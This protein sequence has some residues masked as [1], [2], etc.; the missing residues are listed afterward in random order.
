MKEELEAKVKALCELKDLANAEHGLQL[1]F[2][3]DDDWCVV[4]KGVRFS[5]LPC[6]SV[7]KFL[8]NVLCGKV[9]S[10]EDRGKKQAVEYWKNF[11][12]E[13]TK[14]E[15]EKSVL[16]AEEVLDAEPKKRGRKPKK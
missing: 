14:K 12:M 13:K 2:R 6:A 4:F 1:N 16:D 15:E 11:E 10:T 8:E 9:E 7:D 5:E 3:N